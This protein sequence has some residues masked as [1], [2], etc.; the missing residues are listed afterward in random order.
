MKLQRIRTVE[1]IV[2]AGVIAIIRASSADEAVALAQACR[3]GGITALEITYTTPGAEAAIRTLASAAGRDFVLGAGTV[4]DPE[5]ARSAILAGAE[6]LVTPAL[7][8]ATVRLANRYQIPCIPGAMT[9]EG[10]IR[11][12]ECGADLVKL[13]PGELFGPA[14]VRAIHGPL[15]QANL[16]PTGGVSLEN[17]REWIEAGAVAV[18]VG[19]ALT[20]PAQSGGKQAVAAAAKKFLEQVRAARER[21]GP[22]R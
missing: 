14:A 8:E 3:E 13:F 19:G 16:I 12:M 9:V 5:T 15:P 22:A 7:E 2:D 18:A 11:A 6:Y 10:V 1:R 20:R 4:L 17:V 21:S